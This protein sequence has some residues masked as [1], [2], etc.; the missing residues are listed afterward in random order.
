MKRARKVPP[1]LSWEG[2]CAGFMVW[3]CLVTA[4]SG[5]AATINFNAS[6]DDG[7]VLKGPSGSNLNGQVRFGVFWNQN[8]ATPSFLNEAA[9]GSIWSTNSASQRFSALQA[10]FLSL[11][12]SDIS[13]T[14]GYFSFSGTANNEYDTG[15]VDGN[16]DA[17]L[18]GMRDAA[19]F[20]FVVD[21]FS[22]PTALAVLSAVFS[23]VGDENDFFDHRHIHRKS[24]TKINWK[25]LDLKS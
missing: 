3:A 17:I 9:V 4:G 18:V 11:T 14:N 13:V 12:S 15:M 10:S 23:K 7:T 16:G 8:A 1:F 24:I 5:Y 20:A 22:S 2:L 19:I 21:S 6:I 25:D